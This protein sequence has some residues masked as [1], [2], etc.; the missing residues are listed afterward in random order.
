MK[1]IILQET[2]AKP[3]ANFPVLTLAAQYSTSNFCSKVFITLG[4]KYYAQNIFQKQEQAL[5]QTERK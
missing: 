3:Y 5:F 1:G 2:M 4:L